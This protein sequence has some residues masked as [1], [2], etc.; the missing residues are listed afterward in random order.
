MITAKYQGITGTGNVVVEG[1]SLVS[2][3]V[4]VP[5]QNQPYTVPFDVSVQFQATGTFADNSTQNLTTN[6]TWASSQPSVAT[7]SNSVGRQG[8]ATGVSAGQTEITAVFA[9][10]AGNATL[11]VTNATLVSITVTPANQNVSVGTQVGYTAVGKFS[12]GSTVD[13]TGQCTWV[14]TKPTVATINNLGQASAASAGTTSI[15]AT[16]VQNGV[17][18]T[19]M[20]NL[21]VH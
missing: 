7:I 13:L 20:T 6:V 12:D 11:N 5:I 18:V 8:L 10:I 14:S 16:F 1:S 19:G 9:S 15:Q 21:T 4:T 2:I 17:S 3:A